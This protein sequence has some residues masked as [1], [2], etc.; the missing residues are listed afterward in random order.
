MFQLLIS[1]DGVHPDSVGGIQTEKVIVLDPAIQGHLAVIALE[2]VVI[3]PS[4]DLESAGKARGRDA[5]PKCVPRQI[6]A[7]I[8]PPEMI[9]QPGNG[10][11]SEGG[12]T[13][14]RG[15][16]RPGSRSFS[17]S[18]AEQRKKNGKAQH[19]REIVAIKYLEPIRL[20]R[21]DPGNGSPYQR[22]QCDFAL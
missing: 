19:Q 13:N 6:P 14:G 9:M 4:V 10:K 5:I 20:H 21:E 8:V 12:S 2:I 3:Q 7:C 11:P 15:D 18:G 1:P 22:K 16:I 17:S